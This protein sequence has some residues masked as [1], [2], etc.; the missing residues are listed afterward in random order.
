M[1]IYFEIREDKL[2]IGEMTRHPFPLHLHEEAEIVAVTAGKIRIGID[3][4]L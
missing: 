2:F 3:G 4:I 1:N